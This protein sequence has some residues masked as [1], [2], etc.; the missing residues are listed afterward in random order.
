MRAKNSMQNAVYPYPGADAISLS[1]VEPT[2]LRYRLLIHDGI[3]G[4]KIAW[5]YNQYLK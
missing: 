3:S 4:S 1:N 5:L 2:V